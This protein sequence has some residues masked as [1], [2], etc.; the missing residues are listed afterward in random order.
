MIMIQ[1]RVSKFSSREGDSYKFRCQLC[2]SCYNKKV[3]IS[4]GDLHQNSDL[5]PTQNSDFAPHT[6]DESEPSN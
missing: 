2:N 4:A 1:Q 3:K 6:E 5:Y